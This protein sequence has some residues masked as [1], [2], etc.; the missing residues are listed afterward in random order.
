MTSTRKAFVLILL[1]VAALTLALIVLIR[2]RSVDD[3]ML[4]TIAVLGAL[5]IILNSLPAGN[6]KRHGN[7]NGPLAPHPG[8]MPPPPPQPSGPDPGLPEKSD[9]L[10]PP[11]PPPGT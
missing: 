7:G 2:N 4:A 3:E 10:L 11:P 1:G 8:P 6:G 9:V 5:A